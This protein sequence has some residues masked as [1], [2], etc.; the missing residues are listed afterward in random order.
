V[1]F[2]TRARYFACGLVVGVL[3]LS[4]GL[5][6]AKGEFKQVPKPW[7]RS[8]LCVHRYEGSWRDPDGPY[9][10]GLQMD[11]GFQRHYGGWMLKH[12]GTADHWSPRAQL[13]VA[14]RGYRQRS[15][16]PWPLTAAKCGLI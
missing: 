4:V 1:S 3:L 7:L 6:R 13:I 15:W 9:Y 10:G 12:Y 2:Q 14:F 11:L 5:G 16:E 8:A